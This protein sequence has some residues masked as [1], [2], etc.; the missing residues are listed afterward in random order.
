MR[1]RQNATCWG[2]AGA[3]FARDGVFTD[4]GVSEHAGREGSCVL[5][6]YGG[7]DES[8]LLMESSRAG[9]LQY[10]HIPLNLV[11]LHVPRMLI[12][13]MDITRDSVPASLNYDVRSC[14]RAYK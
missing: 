10:D 13:A 7:A 1:W 14:A 9:G 5:L 3:P 6:L 2:Y 12:P 11:I 8:Y 4:V